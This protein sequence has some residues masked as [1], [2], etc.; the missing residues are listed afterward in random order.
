VP[1]ATTRF[2]RAGWTWNV[3]RMSIWW[4]NWYDALR[5][6]SEQ[7]ELRQLLQGAGRIDGFLRGV[8]GL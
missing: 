1:R 7:A 3:T 5:W 8:G 6:K 2:T 4:P